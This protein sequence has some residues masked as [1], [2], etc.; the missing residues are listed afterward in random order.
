MNDFKNLTVEIVEKKIRLVSLFRNHGHEQ[1]I[2]KSCEM[3]QANAIDSEAGCS[4]DYV[5]ETGNL[6]LEIRKALQE[7]RYPGRNLIY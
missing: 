1:N 3:T 2:K 5:W 4:V 7:N 6:F